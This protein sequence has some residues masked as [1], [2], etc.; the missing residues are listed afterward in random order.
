MVLEKIREIVVP[1]V[2]LPPTKIF[3]PDEW[4]I[5]RD[6]TVHEID[7]VLDGI[8]AQIRSGVMKG[9]ITGAKADELRLRYNR[10]VGEK[11]LYKR[12]TTKADAESRG[13]RLLDD[14]YGLYKDAIDA[15]KIG[16][17]KR[18]KEII[19]RAVRK[20]EE[21]YKRDVASA[22]EKLQVN[23]KGLSGTL[24]AGLPV[25]AGAMEAVSQA[26]RTA[27]SMFAPTKREIVV[28]EKTPEEA[29]PEL[30]KE[31]EVEE[32]TW[33]DKIVTYAKKKP[34]Q[35]AG[36]VILG[37]VTARIAIPLVAGA[38]SGA[39]RAKSKKYAFKGV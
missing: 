25:T 29:I 30:K 36:M 34:L 9:Y 33:T 26:H 16:G 14:A 1:H 17:E 15:Y 10:I 2:G 24:K 12:K 4:K 31:L 39:K 19:E 35:L 32:V 37:A 21:E 8:D 13:K 11:D 20:E 18:E 3:K 38:I 5:Y 23:V 7:D 27:T 6:T 28:V 22:W